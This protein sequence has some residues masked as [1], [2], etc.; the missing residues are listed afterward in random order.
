MMRARREERREDKKKGETKRNA[1]KKEGEVRGGEERVT[2]NYVI[3]IFS[4]NVIT[5]SYH[6]F[7]VVSSFLL[8][9][10]EPTRIHVYV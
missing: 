9:H 4:T 3:I 2:Y 1:K 8:L 5:F 10:G 6:T 7:V